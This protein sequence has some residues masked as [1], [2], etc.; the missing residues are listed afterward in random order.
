MDLSF[1][2]KIGRK[3]I[4]KSLN[5]TTQHQAPVES[6][7]QLGKVMHIIAGYLAWVPPNTPVRFAVWDISD[8]FWRV[9]VDPNDAWNFSFRHPTEPGEDIAIAVPEAL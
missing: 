7:D 9:C 6:L 8:G 3:V 2:D 5:E 4:Q 1:P